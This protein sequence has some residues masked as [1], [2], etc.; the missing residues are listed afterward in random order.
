MSLRDSYSRLKADIKQRLKGGKR[1]PEGTGIDSPT[2]SL[3]QSEPHDAR[4]SGRHRGGDGDDADGWDTHP[5]DQPV[6]RDGPEPENDREGGLSPKETSQTQNSPP[7]PDIE[8]AV[9]SGRSGG[10]ERV[11]P[12]LSFTLPLQNAEFDST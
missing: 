4:G 6:Q 2:G 5:A 9:D 7:G 12:S 3:P 10:A 11:H 1:K 8:S